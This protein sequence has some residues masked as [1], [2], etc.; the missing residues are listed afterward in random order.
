MQSMYQRRVGKDYPMA[1]KFGKLSFKLSLATAI[2][3][4]GLTIIIVGISGL[5][6]TAQ[7]RRP[8][9]PVNNFNFT[10]LQN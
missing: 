8:T 3:V 4:L 5:S 9:V 7:F 6:V 10:T 1:E 2:V